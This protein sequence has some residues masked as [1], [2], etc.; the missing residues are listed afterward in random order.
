MDPGSNKPTVKRYFWDN[1]KKFKYK[2]DIRW[3]KGIII[4]LLDWIMIFI[5]KFTQQ[6]EMATRLEEVI[7]SS[8]KLP[9]LCLPGR[10]KKKKR[11]DPSCVCAWSFPFQGKGTACDRGL[12]AAAFSGRKLEDIWETKQ[13]SNL[14]DPCVRKGTRVT[15]KRPRFES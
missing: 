4:I 7:L 6:L 14:K 5:F 13:S 9:H 3:Y 10:K 12:K 15:I 1:W 8:Q 2:M 11:I